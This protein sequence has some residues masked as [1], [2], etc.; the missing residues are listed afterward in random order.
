MTSG[1]DAMLDAIAATS[2]VADYEKV[3]RRAIAFVSTPGRDQ[4]RS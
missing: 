1:R 4:P 2:V 3:V